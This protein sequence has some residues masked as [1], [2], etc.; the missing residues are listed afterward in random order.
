MKD[1]KVLF[2]PDVHCRDFW[3]EPV[4]KTLEE[5][6][7]AKIVFLG[8]YLDGYDFDFGEDVDYQ[9]YGFE[10]FQEIVKLKE[11]YKDRITLLLGNH[12]CTY[13]IGDDICKCRTDYKHKGQ[14]EDIFLGN[15]PF[16][17]FADQ[18][19]INGKHFIFVHAGVTKGW[20]DMNFKDLKID[21]DNI[22][23]FLNAMWLTQ[24][25][26]NLD[27]F[28][29]YDG[30]RSYFG[31]KYGSPIWADMRATYKVPKEEMY[32][33]FQIVGHTQLSTDEPLISDCIGDFDCRHCF[34]IDSEANIRKYD[35]D[36]ICEK[37]KPTE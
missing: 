2:I 7:E 32:G 30:Y 18:V 36:K 21:N 10:N 34:Y 26:E 9:T 12:D 5:N 29:Q 11:Q 31:Y 8:D 23:D 16:F 13:A 1:I 15:I 24:D 33:D 6:P 14:L 19:K 3:K 35:D 17:Q 25:Y 22:V 28:G 4:K 20:I 37:T 27:R